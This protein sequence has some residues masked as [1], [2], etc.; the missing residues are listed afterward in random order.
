MYNQSS[1]LFLLLATFSPLITDNLFV[2]LTLSVFI[3]IDV[4]L[5]FLSNLFSDLSKMKV[6][7]PMVKYRSS[8]SHHSPL[9]LI[10]LELH[11]YLSPR[12]DKYVCSP[13]RIKRIMWQHVHH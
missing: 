4:L 11:T 2:T 3:I 6:L 7:Y 1:E 10:L 13:S 5:P 12:G 9:V 8:E